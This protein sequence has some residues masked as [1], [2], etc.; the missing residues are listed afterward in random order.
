MIALD[1][2]ELWDE[3]ESLVSEN[4][5]ELLDEDEVNG[6]IAS[7]NTFGWEVDSFKIESYEMYCDTISVVITF[8]CFGEINPDQVFSGN[9]IFGKATMLFDENGY[10]TFEDISAKKQD[11][12]E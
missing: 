7:T 6:L 11:L 1:G 3:I 12:F 2:Q 10:R 9:R 4:V 5:H 8:S